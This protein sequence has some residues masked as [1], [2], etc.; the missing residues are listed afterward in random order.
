VIAKLRNGGFV[1][2][3]IEPGRRFDRTLGFESGVSHSGVLQMCRDI[4]EAV[5]VLRASRLVGIPLAD[6]RLNATDLN[7]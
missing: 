7:L 4:D 6:L 1:R 2:E 5:T 3:L